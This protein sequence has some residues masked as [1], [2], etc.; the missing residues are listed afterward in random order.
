MQ[1]AGMDDPDNAPFVHAEYQHIYQPSTMCIGAA[2]T[3]PETTVQGGYRPGAWG[4][5]PRQHELP[6]QRFISPAALLPSSFL[7]RLTHIGPLIGSDTV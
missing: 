7:D 1:R 4:R 6:N 3:C 5:G 2:V